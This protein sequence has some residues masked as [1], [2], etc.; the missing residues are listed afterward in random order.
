[1]GKKREPTIAQLEALQ[2]AR[3]A[4][5]KKRKKKKRKRKGENLQ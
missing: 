4:L 5:A 1:M 3:A 2:K